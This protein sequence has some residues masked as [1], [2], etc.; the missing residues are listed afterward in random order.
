[1]RKSIHAMPGEGNEQKLPDCR[2]GPGNDCR[3]DSSC[4]YRQLR[5]RGYGASEG[6]GPFGM[7]LVTQSLHKETMRIKKVFHQEEMLVS[8]RS[9]KYL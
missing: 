8:S 4:S 2:R 3:A 1:M 7:N 9:A 6:F 5:Y